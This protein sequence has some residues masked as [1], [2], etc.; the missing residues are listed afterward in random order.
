MS[1]DT[2]R[3]GVGERE[4]SQHKHLQETLDKI[5]TGVDEIKTRLAAGDT[6]MTLLDYRVT[7]IEVQIEDLREKISSDQEEKQQDTIRQFRQKDGRAWDVWKIVIAMI[8]SA[9]FTLMVSG[10]LHTIKGEVGHATQDENGKS[11]GTK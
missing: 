6:K 4:C 5:A 3:D 1:A 11:E 9:A 2:E 10:A 8:L 7:Q